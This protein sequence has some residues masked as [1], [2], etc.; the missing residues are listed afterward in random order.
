M[1]ARCD[2]APRVEL[3]PQR[4]AVKERWERLMECGRRSRRCPQETTQETMRD[5]LTEDAGDDR[6]CPGERTLVQE[7]T[8]KLG[9]LEELCAWRRTKLGGVVEAGDWPSL[10]SPPTD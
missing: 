9:G 1:A 10:S 2:G 4:R 5:H 6:V 3:P 8:P 7:T